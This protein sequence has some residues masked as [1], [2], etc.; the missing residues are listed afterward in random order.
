MAPRT[1]RPASLG[2]DVGK[3]RFGE[4][5]QTPGEIKER[6]NNEVLALLL[7]SALAPSSAPEAHQAVWQ[8]LG[9]C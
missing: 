9:V 3:M 5:R 7:T 4:M 2:Q 6:E 1:R 8:R